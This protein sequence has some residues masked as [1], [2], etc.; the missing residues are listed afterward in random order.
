MPEGMSTTNVLPQQ[1]GLMDQ[2]KGKVLGNRCCLHYSCF[3]TAITSPE[4]RHTALLSLEDPHPKIC[5]IC[6]F[7]HHHQNLGQQ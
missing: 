7:P 3:L 1:G 6:P 2:A 4:W 5:L